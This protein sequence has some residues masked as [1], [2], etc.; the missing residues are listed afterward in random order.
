MC[1]PPTPHSP[2]EPASCVGLAA[3]SPFRCAR[4]S[5]SSPA[6]TGEA[7]E[8][9]HTPQQ[10]ERF[11]S[12]ARLLTQALRS[13]GLS[14][15]NAGNDFPLAFDCP[16]ARVRAARVRERLVT[17][18]PEVRS[19]TT[20]DSFKHSRKPRESSIFCG[21]KHLLHEEGMARVRPGCEGEVKQVRGDQHP[22]PIW[23]GD[24]ARPSP[25]LI[26]ATGGG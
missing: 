22:P 15:I 25:P 19:K 9:P 8:S 16:C 24:S 11:N 14:T 12:N 17:E 18:F 7:P 2:G 6:C 4:W 5:E 26:P 10:S 20:M 1:V 21:R 3:G 13:G 23:A